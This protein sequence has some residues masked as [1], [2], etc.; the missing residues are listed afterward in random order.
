M[1]GNL[2]AVFLHVHR[3]HLDLELEEHTLDVDSSEDHRVQ[4]GSDLA[5]CLI[6]EAICTKRLQTDGRTDDGRRA[7]VLAHWNELRK[8][9]FLLCGKCIGRPG[10]GVTSSTS[11]WCLYH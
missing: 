7:I 3:N 1:K 11:P 2:C 6:E 4:V 9:I 5:I 8:L 10:R